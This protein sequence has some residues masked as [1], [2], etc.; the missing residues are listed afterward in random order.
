[1]VIIVAT[2]GGALALAATA[3]ALLVLGMGRSTLSVTVP[4]GWDLGRRIFINLLT[5]IAAV[6]LVGRLQIEARRPLP[7][8][9]LVLL[10]AVG[11]AGVRGL[12]QISVGIYSQNDVLPALADA[13]I[14][15]CMIG[16]IVTFAVVLTRT[17]Q[18]VRLAERA[19]FLPSTRSAGA[20]VTML[21]NQM[22][23]RQTMA[24]DVQT[25]LGDRFMRVIDELAEMADEAQS[26]QRLRLQTV[27][28][29]LTEIVV[30]GRRSV[31]VFAYPEALEHGLVPAVRALLSTVPQPIVVRLTEDDQA[32]V[33]E[34][35]GF[36]TRGIDRRA[37]LVQA[38]G[39]AI[40]NA[41]EHGH[42]NR[43]EVA[44]SAEAGMVRLA[45]TD[46]GVPRDQELAD[47]VRIRAQMA[48]F[49]GKITTEDL[50]AGGCRVTVLA[51][52]T[53]PRSP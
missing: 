13:A 2:L 42:A 36:G 29:E 35:A 49:G 33:N 17:Q 34:I 47:L 30:E 10:T 48:R 8:A 25:A 7:A 18:R 45:V 53:P 52:P 46:D 41:L 38:V 19:A 28:K 32:A 21:R 40:M 14:T 20:L 39:E 23:G 6:L 51:P 44:I 15:G 12:L 24:T 1:M 37:I 26:L 22:R 31:A 5:V 11:T 3:Q 43:V 4:F 9:G 27:G 50:P 16:L